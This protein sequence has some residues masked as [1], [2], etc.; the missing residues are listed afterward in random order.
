[1]STKVE[2]D[3]PESNH[4]HWL[5]ISRI[6]DKFKVVKKDS[7]PVFNEDK[8]TYERNADGELECTSGTHNTS[9]AGKSR[10]TTPSDKLDKEIREAIKSIA[11]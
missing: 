11:A 3:R 4:D 8:Y 5:E 2:L 6:R 1:M 10:S 7:M 9:G